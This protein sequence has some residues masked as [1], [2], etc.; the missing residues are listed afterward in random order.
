MGV[1][2]R[3]RWV[4]VNAKKEEGQINK[5]LKPDFHLEAES[6]ENSR[7]SAELLR[8]PSSWSLKLIA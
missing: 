5:L 2:Y 3:W 7:L 8:A 1:D 6:S 4:N